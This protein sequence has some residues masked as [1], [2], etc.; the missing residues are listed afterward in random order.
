[1][2]IPFLGHLKYLP[3]FLIV[4]LAIGCWHYRGSASGWEQKASDQKKRADDEATAN[5]TLTTAN[6]AL[7]SR[8][9]NL[10]ESLDARSNELQAETRRANANRDAYQQAIDSS[11]SWADERVPDAVARS[12]LAA[13]S[14]QD[15]SST[16]D[17]STK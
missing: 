8:N 1:M 15:S 9:T 3:Y 17:T 2:K 13:T 4:V 16:K 10:V 12:L 11:R 5:V 7:N 14:V 6:A